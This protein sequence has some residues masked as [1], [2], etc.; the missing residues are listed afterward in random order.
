M[1]TYASLVSGASINIRFAQG[2]DPNDDVH[3]I[4]GGDIVARFSGSDGQPLSEDFYKS[5]KT[6]CSATRI[7]PWVPIHGEADIVDLMTNPIAWVTKLDSGKFLKK[8]R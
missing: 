6:E 1:H 8:K 3:P 2:V 4:T 5:L 7:P